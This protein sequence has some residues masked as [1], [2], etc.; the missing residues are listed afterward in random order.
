MKKK[1]IATLALAGAL[2]VSM[3]PAFAANN[4]TTVGY[5]AGGNA[6]TDGRVMVTIP[7]DVTFTEEGDTGKVTGFDVKAMVWDATT[8]TWATP[9]TGDLLLKTPITVGV[10]STEG[11]R[12]ANAGAQGVGEYSYAVDNTGDTNADLTLTATNNITEDKKEKALGT[13]KDADGQGG[14]A[15]YTLAG[16]VTM[17]KTPSV[18]QLEKPEYFSDTLT[19]SFGG[20]T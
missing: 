8:A 2:A 14:A 20:L 18:G 19:Y 12:L 17:T 10:T 15:V 6:S 5:T 4:Q 11:F 7:M 3:V 13:L 9:G 16:T 1:G